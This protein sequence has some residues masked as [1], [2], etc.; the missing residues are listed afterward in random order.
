MGTSPFL[1][2]STVAQL[3]RILI[4]FSPLQN[5]GSGATVAKMPAEDSAPA[6]ASTAFRAAF[7]LPTEADLDDCLRDLADWRPDPAPE[8]PGWQELTRAAIAGRSAPF[9]VSDHADNTEFLFLLADGAE[10]GQFRAE[11]TALA[12]H[13]RDARDWNLRRSCQQVTQGT[14][15]L[16]PALAILAELIAHRNE[17]DRRVRR[18]VCALRE[19]ASPQVG[20]AELAAVTG[21]SISGVRASYDDEIRDEV[22]RILGRPPR[23]SRDP[24]PVIWTA[25][26]PTPDLLLGAESNGTPVELPAGQPLLVAADYEHSAAQDLHATLT[27]QLLR[28]NLA[29]WWD[30]PNG[31][32]SREDIDTITQTAPPAV[33]H[34][35]QT[36]AR[37]AEGTAKPEQ[38]T[39]VPIHPSQLQPGSIYRIDP[40]S[41]DSPPPTAGALIG[42]VR[43]ETTSAWA[44]TVWIAHPPQRSHEWAWTL[45]TPC[46]KTRT[47][48]TARVD[49]DIPTLLRN[50]AIGAHWPHNLRE[51]T[52]WYIDALTPTESG[53]NRFS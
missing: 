43:P 31:T 12:H 34:Y 51:A 5:Y 45:H 13:L 15:D 41:A 33:H 14:G 17:A 23:K 1:Y 27:Q 6:P 40:P 52:A 20:L 9:E 25:A 7:A 37:P 42:P 39:P 2:F 49:H 32:I 28:R 38:F 11:Y 16:P 3:Y 35:D 44:N 22:R 4:F 36:A 29:H 26:Q 21:G 8:P 48:R 46:G 30:N 10:S 24:A 47:F 50:A 53:H 19:W 18:A